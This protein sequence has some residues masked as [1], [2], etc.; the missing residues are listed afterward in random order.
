LAIHRL[1]VTLF[2]AL[3][4][5]PV[6]PIFSARAAEP[7]DSLAYEA[8]RRQI[9]ENAPDERSTLTLAAAQELA[10]DGYYAEALELIYSMQG[11]PEDGEWERDFDSVLAA[12]AGSDSGGGERPGAPPAGKASAITGYVQTSVDYEEWEHLDT[13]VGGRVRA[14][15]E[16]DPPG[17][18]DRLTALFQASDR[19]AYF[20][21]SGKG[22]LYGGSFK[23]DGDA[24]VE[25]KIWRSNQNVYEDSVLVQ[26][27]YGDSLDRLFLQARAEGN[28]RRFGKPLS[29]VVPAYAEA[30]LYRHDRPGSYSYRAFGAAP[31]LEAV[32]ENLLKSLILSWD[33]RRTDYPQSPS[34]SNF[35]HGPVASGEWYGRRV[36]IDAETRFINYGYD[37][38]TSLTRI[39]RLETR[40]GIFVRTW[41]WL[42]AGIRTV[43]E[44]ETDEYLDTVDVI[45]LDRLPARYALEGASWSLQPQLVAEWAAAYSASLGL[46]FTR[47]TYPIMDAI[48][49]QTL[50]FPL[51]QNYSADDWKAEAGFSIL[52]KAIFFTLSLDY[53][54]NWVANPQIYRQGSSKGF[55]LN[56]NLFWKLHRWFEL[57]L[58]C[59][60]AHRTWLAEGYSSGAISNV[61]NLSLGLT[62]RF[63]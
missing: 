49:G 37:R 10:R 22:S 48:D 62:S 45:N 40:A 39:N 53:E 12:G 13:L 29:V 31:G 44:S 25:K 14:K 55:G 18:V 59:N 8:K 32:S 1:L 50:L 15:L 46:A 51:Y 34:S 33:L 5:A 38:D 54:E 21:F 60:A 17:R 61:V 24:L 36:T 19:N 27:S 4:L 47:G 6:S 7:A 43:G 58:S 16:W 30:E 9:L 35:R 41:R 2:L 52:S 63:P 28:T 57:D 11:K 56:G 23:L 42:R 3:L 26:H 20:D